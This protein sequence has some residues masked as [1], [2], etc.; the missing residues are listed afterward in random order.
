MNC[1]ITQDQHT[2]GFEWLEDHLLQ[3]IF[4]FDVDDVM[5]MIEQVTCQGLTK[6]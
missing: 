3:K 6:K 5:A 1:Q 2:A 4:M